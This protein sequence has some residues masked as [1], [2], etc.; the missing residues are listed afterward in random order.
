MK[1]KIHVGFN[2]RYHRSLIKAKEIF[3][4]HVLGE[5]MYLRGRYGHGGRLGYEK[6]WRANPHLS[7]GGELLI[8][9]LT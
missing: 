3:D 2:H 4:S 8:K 5:I 7:G 9:V 6:E 1:K